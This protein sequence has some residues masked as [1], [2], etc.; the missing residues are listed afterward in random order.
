MRLF[1]RTKQS[2]GD[3]AEARERLLK[4][5]TMR[6]SDR[7]H[8]SACDIEAAMR[9][10]DSGDL[11]SLLVILAPPPSDPSPAERYSNVRPFS[12]S[13]WKRRHGQPD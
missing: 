13:D 1:W 9:T 2:A 3:M 12:H 4:L 8:P 7:P 11:D 5:T 10:I 6:A